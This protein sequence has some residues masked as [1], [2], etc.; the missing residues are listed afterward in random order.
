M[1]PKEAQNS[2]HF[3]DTSE[4]LSFISHYV[5]CIGKILVDAY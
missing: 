2:H 1:K 3:T 5:K 4:Y